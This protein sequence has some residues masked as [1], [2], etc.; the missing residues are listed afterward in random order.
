MSLLW[1][2]VVDSLTRWEAFLPC[3]FSQIWWAQRL[4]SLSLWGL[5]AATQLPNRDASPSQTISSHVLHTTSSSQRKNGFS[6]D[7]SHHPNIQQICHFFVRPFSAS[8]RNLYV[9]S[10]SSAMAVAKSGQGWWNSDHFLWHGCQFTVSSH[11]I[12]CLD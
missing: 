2:G 3:G 9:T 8:M 1:G 5:S 10:D 12:C 4:W 6:E 11:L 7:P